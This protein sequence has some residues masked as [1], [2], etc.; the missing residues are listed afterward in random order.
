MS[1]ILIHKIAQIVEMNQGWY[2]GEVRE[3]PFMCK[4][5]TTLLRK[6]ESYCLILSFTG[7]TDYLALTSVI[8]AYEG[9]KNCFG[10]TPKL[11][12]SVFTHEHLFMYLVKIGRNWNMV[13]STRMQGNERDRRN[14]ITLPV[15]YFVFEG[16]VVGIACFPFL[17]LW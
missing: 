4:S 12:K 3:L 17:T 8:I 10:A 9:T 15:K 11:V 14:L 6:N 16:L 1:W 5:V 2:F 13:D 7:E